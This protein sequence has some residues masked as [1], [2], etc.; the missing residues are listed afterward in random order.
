MQDEDTST[1]KLQGEDASI[2]EEN[3]LA[4]YGQVVRATDEGLLPFPIIDIWDWEMFTETAKKGHKVAKLSGR[5]A[6][7]STKFHPSV[8]AGSGRLKT[9]SICDVHLDLVRVAS[10]KVYR[11]RHPSRRYLASLSAY[12]SSNPTNDWG[13]PNLSIEMQKTAPDRN[14]QPGES[15]Y[16]NSVI[17]GESN[18]THHVVSKSDRQS[19]LPYRDRAAERRALHGEFSTGPGQRKFFNDDPYGEESTSQTNGEEAAAEA[20]N[21]TFGQ[22]SYA[23]KLLEK[24]GW[25]DGQALGC[26]NKGIVQPLQAIGNKGN[27]GLGWT[28]TR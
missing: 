25:K 23:R 7:H 28:H 21:L 8:P 13:F 10:G 26:T 24:M 12:D 18:A 27:A 15:N 17:H 1:E 16:S 4:Q 22:G 20:M 14:S 9:A 3:W 6:N 19:S 2:D 11:L 5:L